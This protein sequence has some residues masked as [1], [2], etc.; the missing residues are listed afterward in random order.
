[1]GILERKKSGSSYL[2]IAAGIVVVLGV[3]FT[4]SEKY[5]FTFSCDLV[6]KHYEEFALHI[7]NALYA[8]N[9]LDEGTFSM[10][11]GDH[12]KYFLSNENIIIYYKGSCKSS[13]NFISLKHNLNN[14]KPST[15]E[16]IDFCVKKEKGH[17]KLC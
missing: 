17:I 7:L 13:K 15:Y 12:F 6:E 9:R 11:I 3:I 4:V 8:V 14:V 16:G 2:I 10:K 1:M 5:N